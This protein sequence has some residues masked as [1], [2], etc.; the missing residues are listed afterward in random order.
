MQGV[1]RTGLIS[2]APGAA[3]VR[4]HGGAVHAAIALHKAGVLSLRHI[5][6][7]EVDPARRK[8]LRDWLAAQAL[9]IIHIDCGDIKTLSD[10]AFTEML[11]RI[12]GAH[13]I[14]ASPPCNQLSGRNR[15]AADTVK[16]RSGLSGG[17]EA[18]SVI[19]FECVRLTVAAQLVA[20]AWWLLGCGC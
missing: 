3:V 2:I 17:P 11:R 9:N 1:C 5:V 8:V 12:G 6:T 15:G 13:I 18:D 4:G 14:V 20:L 10:G 7:V 16:G 19:F